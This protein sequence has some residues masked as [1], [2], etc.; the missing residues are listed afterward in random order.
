MNIL[1]AI[2]GSKFSQSAIH[3]L[4]AQATPGQTNLRIL[5]VIEPIPEYADSL[6]WGYGMQVGSVLQEE[7]EHAQGLVARAAQELRDA[8]FQV[9]TMVE[10]G[11]AKAVILDCAA[12]WPADLIVLGSHG[13]KGL[14]RFLMGSVSEAVARHAPCS[15]QI[16]RSQARTGTE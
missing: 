9:E 1:L 15:V 7:R 2:D 16:V 5:H 11:D 8:G 6:S 3:A 10:V 13:R 12:Q 4:I 14:E